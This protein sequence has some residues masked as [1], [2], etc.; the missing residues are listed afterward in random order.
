MLPNDKADISE[1]V[2]AQRNQ[3]PKSSSEFDVDSLALGGT[4]LPHDL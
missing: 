4:D 3:I 1:V 2:M